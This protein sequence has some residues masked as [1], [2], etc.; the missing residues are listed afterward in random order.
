MDVQSV[1]VVVGHDDG[2]GRVRWEVRGGGG[3]CVRNCCGC[4]DCCCWCLG[5]CCDSTDG[6]GERLTDVV[7][8]GVAD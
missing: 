3:C 6:D 1:V 4:D 5:A 8:E 2:D 7:A